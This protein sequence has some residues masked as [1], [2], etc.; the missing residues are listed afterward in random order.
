MVVDAAIQLRAE[1]EV[2]PGGDCLR[3]IAE[4]LGQ[5]LDLASRD[6]LERDCGLPLLRAA[7]RLMPP[8]GSSS[9]C[10]PIPRLLPAPGSEAPGPSMSR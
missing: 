6:E 5:T 10:A 3:L 4:D 7:L 8:P 1:A 9:P 2:I